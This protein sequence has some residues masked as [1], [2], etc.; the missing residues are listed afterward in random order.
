MSED[1]RVARGPHDKHAVHA[2]IVDRL[3]Q[4][5]EEVTRM[6]AGLSEADLARRT[7]ADKWSVKELLC[8]L[9]RIQEVFDERVEAMLAQEN[10]KLPAYEPDGDPGFAARVQRPATDTLATFLVRR[11]RL[12]GR[13]EELRP[14]DWHRP[15]QH[16]EYA[17]YDVHFCVEYLAH[18]EAH[19][20]YQMFQRRAPLGPIPH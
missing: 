8:H 6:V 19:H 7:V 9:D 17:H 10:P 4:H 5:A 1:A 14:S 11:E 3:Q 15:G 13:L 2:R 16:P 18:H 20:L 12:V